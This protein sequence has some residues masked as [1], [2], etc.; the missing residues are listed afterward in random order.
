[1][2]S[3]RA[4]SVPAATTALQCLLRTVT[5]ATCMLTLVVNFLLL[6][7]VRPGALRRC[8]LALFRA[9]WQDPHEAVVN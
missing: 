9:S 8:N 4:C 7:C 1:M 6:S 3:G 5:Q 2:L